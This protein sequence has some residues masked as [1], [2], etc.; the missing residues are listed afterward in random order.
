MQNWKY[1]KKIMNPDSI[2]K[3]GEL[4]SFRFD[5]DTE[6]FL[7]THNNGRPSLNEV[8]NHDELVF[9]KLLSFN[10][11]DIENVFKTRESLRGLL[12]PT[13]MPIGADPFGN[14]FCIDQD[15]GAIVFWEHESTNE[16]KIAESL[17][18]LMDLLQ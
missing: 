15:S 13:L 5:N 2:Q 12:R 14:Y 10:K 6:T 7:L 4:Y 8:Q 17:L 16:T 11:D 18:Q 9:D 1:V 3:Y